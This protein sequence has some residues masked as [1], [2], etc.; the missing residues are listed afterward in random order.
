MGRV[1]EYD[2][3]GV[4]KACTDAYPKCMGRAARGGQY[5][6]TCRKRERWCPNGCAVVPR[7]GMLCIECANKRVAELEATDG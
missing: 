4:W 7:K 1:G 2:S 5:N 6:C 3:H